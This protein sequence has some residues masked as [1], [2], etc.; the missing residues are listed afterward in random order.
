MIQGSLCMRIHLGTVI[1]LG[2]WVQDVK[3]FKRRKWKYLILDEAHMIKNWRSQRWQAL[4]NFSA[5]HRLLITGTPL[6]VPQSLLPMCAALAAISR[7]LHMGVFTCYVV[8]RG[9]D[10]FCGAE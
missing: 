7:Y 10:S 6:Q 5:R 8:Q 9:T 1:T 4:L 2:E 3:I